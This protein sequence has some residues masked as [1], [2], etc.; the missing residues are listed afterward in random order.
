MWRRKGEEKYKKEKPFHVKCLLP[1]EVDH[2][3]PWPL[4]EAHNSLSRSHVQ[5][6]GNLWKWLFQCELRI[7]S[8]T[9]TWFMHPFLKP[10]T[11]TNGSLW[12]KTLHFGVVLPYIISK[13]YVGLNAGKIVTKLR[14][15]LAKETMD[16]ME[17]KWQS[18]FNI[19]W[20]MQIVFSIYRP[21]N[22]LQIHELRALS[23]NRRNDVTACSDQ[24]FS[25]EPPKGIFHLTVPPVALNGSIHKNNM[26]YG[27]SANGILEA[28]TL[29]GPRGTFCRGKLSFDALL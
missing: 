8:L 12:A 20:N 14:P 15:S 18:E 6:K 2:F 3:H 7:T 5:T 19:L 21:Y 10:E 13:A 23:R 1:E 27:P 28:Y 26:C 29:C 9:Y 4:A 17:S 25:G 22:S 11:L 16:F 24:A